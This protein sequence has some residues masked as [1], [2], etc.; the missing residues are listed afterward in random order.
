MGVLHFTELR[1]VLAVEQYVNLIADKF[2]D[3]GFG[4]FTTN[5]ALQLGAPGLS[6][7]PYRYLST[8]R[9][10]PG[11]VRCRRYERIS[12]HQ[13]PVVWLQPGSSSLA[14]STAV[15]IQ[16]VSGDYHSPTHRI[17]IRCP[18]YLPQINTPRKV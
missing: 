2:A 8:P 4:L 1:S 11:T 3:V 7:T 12:S 10:S 15:T 9:A 6:W 16:M 17:H 18:R 5:L 13:H 14:L